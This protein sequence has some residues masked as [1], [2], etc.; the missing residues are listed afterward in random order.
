MSRR[1]KWWL[2]FLAKV[3]PVTEAS[4]KATQLPIIGK[5]LSAMVLP[6]FIGRNFNV[7]YI[8]IN[9]ELK[10]PES[11]HLPLLVL[12]ELI[13]RSSCRVTIKRCHCRESKDCNDYPIENACLLM[14][15]GTREID[16]WIADP[17]SVDEAIN[18][19]RHMV[20][21]GLTPMV[22][23]VLMDNLFYGVPNKGNLLTVCFCCHCCCTVMSSAKYFP[24]KAKNSI[25]RIKGMKINVDDQKCSDCRTWNCIDECIVKAYTRENGR[26]VHDAEKCKGCG[27]CVDICPHKAVSVEVADINAAVDEILSRIRSL[28]HYG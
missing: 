27:W 20:S 3:W 14:G 12:E 15:Q 7:S 6:L 8:P 1:P 17:L 9:E 10:S 19:A 5:A 16:P 22:G 25:V 2:T 18:H 21:L 23:R 28:I 26:I 13:R 4:A 24:Q 11:L